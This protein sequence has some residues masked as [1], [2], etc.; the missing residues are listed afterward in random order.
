M[1]ENEQVPKNL[2]Y[3]ETHEWVL[4]EG[5][6]ITIGITEYA[7]SELGDIVFLEL[8]AVGKLVDREESFGTIEAVKTVADLLSPAS[9][10]VVEINDILET[11]PELIN[12][13]PYGD[14]WMVK[15]QLADQSELKELLSPQDYAELQSGG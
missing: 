9:G 1:L 13:D 4:Q 11:Q 5:D 15:L 10:E 12:T 2:L 8:P 14:G 6:T 3:T 7:Q